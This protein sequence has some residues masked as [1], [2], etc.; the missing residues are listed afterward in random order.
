MYLG[1]RTDSP[2]VE[3]YLYSVDG[4][5]IAFAEWRADRGM[6]K[7]LLLHIET[8][9]KTHEAE[10]TLLK[11]VF[12]FAGPGSFTGLRI[13]ITVA[14]A[15]SYSLSVPVVGACGDD[16]W[17]ADCVSRLQ[18]GKN[19]RVVVPFYGAAPRITQPKK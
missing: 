11:G 3:M 13:G 9:L 2:V 18:R 7:G 4:E 15:L 17:A 5:R 14:N 16:I 1:L 10:F 8:F 6:A 19:D 12:V